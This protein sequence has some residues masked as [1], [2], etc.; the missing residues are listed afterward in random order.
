MEM[1]KMHKSYNDNNSNIAEINIKSNLVDFMGESIRESRLIVKDY[2]FSYSYKMKK[3]NSKDD[4]TYKWKYSSSSKKFIDTY[5][6]MLHQISQILKEEHDYLFIT[7]STSY[8]VT[9]KF[10]DGT[11][12]KREYGGTGDQISKILKCVLQMFPQ[13]EE[14]MF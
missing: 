13:L 6:Q 5:N 3:H 2:K 1:L 7:D 11:K 12:L 10:D 8:V 14:I 9:I 4:E